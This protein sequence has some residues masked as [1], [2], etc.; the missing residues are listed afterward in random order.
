MD[1]ECFFVPGDEL[2][3]LSL[4]FINVGPDY[5][6]PMFH[7]SMTDRPCYNLDCKLKSSA[8]ARK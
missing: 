2:F 5:I 4:E 1:F 6:D 7:A 8:Q 3:D